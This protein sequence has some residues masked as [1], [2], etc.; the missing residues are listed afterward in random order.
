MEHTDCILSI[1]NSVFKRHK[2]F[3][4]FSGIFIKYRIGHKKYWVKIYPVEQHNENCKGMHVC[5]VDTEIEDNVYYV[6]PENLKK[7]L[8]SIK[9]H[10]EWKRELHKRQLNTKSD[11]EYNSIELALFMGSHF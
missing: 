5:R 11:E 9:K 1:V 10:L 6:K 2:P 3:F 8:L 4:R 7:W